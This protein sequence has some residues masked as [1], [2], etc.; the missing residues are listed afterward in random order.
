[1]HQHQYPVV[2]LCQVLSVSPSGYYA[3]RK[4]RPSRRQVENDR[5]AAEI[6]QIHQESYQT[7]GSP[8][9]HAELQQQGI[10]C[11]RKRVER[12][13]RLH[14]IRAV[15]KRRRRH[16]TNSAHNLPVAP[17]RLDQDFGAAAPN[18][19]WVADISYIWTT[20]GWLYLAAVLD[21]FSRKIVGWAMGERIDRHLVH[22]ALQMALLTRR[23][24]TES[25]HHSDRG[26]VYA[27]QDYQLLLADHRIQAS[28]RRA[29]NAYDNAVM[30]SFFATLKTEL[31]H[32]RHYQSRA[33]AK[34]GIFAYIEGFYNRRRRHSALGYRSPVAFESL[35]QRCLI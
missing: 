26:S 12:L 29:G 21:L 23:P 15:C 14:Q 35:H 5:L 34:T 2:R 22:Q 4:R 11:N 30:E 28:M 27:S 31:V 3:W 6:R 13:M 7:Y 32:R 25:L 10:A 9:I 8:R 33:E 18:E 20:E 17:N 24:G 19:K 16:T 1:M